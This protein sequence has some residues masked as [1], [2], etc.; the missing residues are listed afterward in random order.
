MGSWCFAV[1]AAWWRGGT[2]IVLQTAPLGK[3]EWI[4]NAEGIPSTW[5]GVLFSQ[6]VLKPI[7]SNTSTVFR[8]LIADHSRK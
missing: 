8:R 7:L 5:L 1:I 3:R 6:V 2:V 4:V